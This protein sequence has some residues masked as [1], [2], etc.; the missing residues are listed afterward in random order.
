[1]TSVEKGLELVGP[2]LAS[3]CLQL[4]SWLSLRGG[5]MNREQYLSVCL[6]L[7]FLQDL[8]APRV[9][10]RPFCCSA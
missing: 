9:T 10:S 6:S 5:R 4:W 1:M 8:P 3:S 2:A 7:I